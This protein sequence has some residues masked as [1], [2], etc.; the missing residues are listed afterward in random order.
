MTTCGPSGTMSFMVE[1][2]P[3][4]ALGDN[5]IW[6]LTDPES[7][8][9]VVVDPGTA[10]PVI[11]WLHQEQHGLA[12]ILI[13]HHHGDHTGGIH[14]LLANDTVPVWG[15]AT[16]RVHGVDRPLGDGDTIALPGDIG[17]LHVIH[18]PGHTAGHICYL[19]D[20]FALTGDTLF[21]GGCGR[22]FE[23]TPQQMH[24]SLA[25]LAALDP[26]T[27][28][29]C[30]HEYTVANL[31][32]AAA[33]EPENPDVAARLETARQHRASGE[34][35]VPSTIAE[36]LATNPFLRA[37]EPSVRR[38]AEHQA[39]RTLNDPVEVFAAVRDWK[40]RF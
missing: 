18:T 21:A 31:C 32:F 40:N 34:P 10:T 14:D 5:Y 33:V 1:L 26:T 39:N 37:E 29:H 38:A 11:R 22:L 20:G 23:G 4:P 19:G 17:Q 25:R 9:A 27:R 16:E 24:Q 15:P 2:T 28:V 6:V 8:H 13:T 36:E 7:R 3:I 35:T 30:A 12:G